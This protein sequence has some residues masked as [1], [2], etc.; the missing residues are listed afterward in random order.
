MDVNNY[1]GAHYVRL[2]LET[3]VLTG[4]KKP[5]VLINVSQASTLLCL[6]YFE[7]FKR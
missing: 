4:E 1:T 5:K 7:L 3:I 2:A 6:N